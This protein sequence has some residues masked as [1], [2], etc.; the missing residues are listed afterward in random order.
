[1]TDQSWAGYQD[2]GMQGG[3]QEPQQGYQEVQ[4][5]GWPQEPQSGYQQQSGYQDQQQSGYQDA[6]QT[7]YQ[8]GGQPGY[9]EG[10]QPGYPQGGQPENQEG[11]PQQGGAPPPPAED[12]GTPKIKDCLTY[13]RNHFK[14]VLGPLGA[15]IKEIRQHGAD[16]WVKPLEEQIE[17]YIVGSGDQVEAAKKHVISVAVAVE[18]EKKDDWDDWGGRK[19]SRR[20]WDD[21]DKDWG[22]RG[23]WDDKD[24]GDRRGGKGG[25]DDRRDGRETE[26]MDL[27]LS[28]FG[29]IVGP[30]GAKIKE[31][32]TNSG[33]HV[34]IDKEEHKVTVKIVGSPEQIASAK[35]MVQDLVS[36][37]GQSKGA[38][39]TETLLFE[40]NVMGNII[41]TGGK[42][43]N[44]V[45]KTC[46]CDVN[47]KKMDDGSCEVIIAGSS[48]SVESAKQMINNF[49]EAARQGVSPQG[50][51]W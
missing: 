26:T 40:G 42:R 7:G 10:G 20:G 24:W 21:K 31:V 9:Q 23:S 48:Q 12:D 14:S 44:D 13:P 5:Q 15:T 38:E 29:C 11:A 43:I 2:G 33:A 25:R 19:W 17:V 3:Y 22:R 35:Q 47:V 46:G 45:R 51:G 4:Q 30:G 18:E 6:P 37:G 34:A 27:D 39:K 32:R 49:V 16:V 1:M 50:Q 28:A 36:G 41:G 8:E